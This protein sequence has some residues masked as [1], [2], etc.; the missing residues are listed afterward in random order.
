M[1]SSCQQQDCVIRG[2]ALWVFTVPPDTSQWEGSSAVDRGEPHGQGA[3]PVFLSSRAGRVGL[4]VQVQGLGTHG[5]VGTLCIHTM[6]PH[7]AITM[8]LLHHNKYTDK[9]IWGSLII[10]CVCL[11]LEI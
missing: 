1:R 10:G 7:C 6:H 3:S 11:G 4:K 9:S 8:P 2:G 5:W